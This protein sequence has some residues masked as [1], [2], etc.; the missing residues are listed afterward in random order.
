[1]IKSFTFTNYLGEPL[2]VTLTEVEPSHGLLIR[3]VEGLGP[4]KAD[5]KRTNFVTRD[6][7]KFNSARRE[8]RNIVID[9]I[10]TGTDIEAV[11]Q[12]TYK[13]FPEKRYITVLVEA[14][15]RTAE[16]YGYVEHNE[17][18]I[19]SD[20]EGTQISIICDD[21]N[22]YSA[23]IMSDQS[24]DFFGAKPLFEFPFE[25]NSLTEKLIEFGS[26]DFYKERVVSYYGD[27]D[28]GII[29]EIHF[30]G[31][32]GNIVI[33]NTETRETMRLNLS[34]IQSIT[35]NPIMA[36]DDIIISTL[37]DKTYVQLLREGV[38]T[39]VLNILDRQSDW[40]QL[41]QGDNVFA[42]TAESGENNIQIRIKNRV[43][44]RGI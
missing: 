26:I 38:Y 5:I 41:T 44:F 39:N 16:A 18:N 24:T 28:V 32:A 21:P 10:F 19:F 6:G 12:L 31:A 37:R 22:F 42:F 2:T 33:Y 9:F 43:V 15:H 17:P 29:I 7:S 20:Q 13:Y 23:G 34:K 30:L 4:V 14:D 35:G 1:M 40:L 27:A 11:R 8:E 3:S 25:N 36:G